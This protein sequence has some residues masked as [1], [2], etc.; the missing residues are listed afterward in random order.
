[1]TTRRGKI[2]QIAVDPNTTHVWGLSEI[3]DL[4]SLKVDPQTGAFHWKVVVP[5]MREWE[6]EYVRA[7]EGPDDTKS[8]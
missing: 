6:Y 4:L 1:M 7:D 8:S 5:V 2:K 3:G